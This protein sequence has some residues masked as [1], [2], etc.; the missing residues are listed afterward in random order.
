[1]TFVTMALVGVVACAAGCHKNAVDKG[2]FKSAINGH[3]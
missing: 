3:F 2:A 1:M